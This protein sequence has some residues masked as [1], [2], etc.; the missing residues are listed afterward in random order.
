MDKRTVNLE[1]IDFDI[2][3]LNTII[4]GTGAAGFNAAD[5]LHSLGQHDIAILTKALIWEL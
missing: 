3:S 1:G 5:A 4:V 2:Y